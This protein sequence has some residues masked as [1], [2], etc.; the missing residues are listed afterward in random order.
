MG[1]LWS[2]TRICWPDIGLEKLSFGFEFTKPE[3]AKW[4]VCCTW[5]AYILPHFSCHSFWVTKPTV[6]CTLPPPPPPPLLTQF[7]ILHLPN[8]ANSP[9][10]SSS[11]WWPYPQQK[12]VFLIAHNYFFYISFCLFIN[13][14]QTYHPFSLILI[15]SCAVHSSSDLSFPWRLSVHLTSLV[16]SCDCRQEQTQR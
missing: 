7:D 10:Q 11:H 13:L 12:D 16:R 1:C 3:V 9:P 6:C 8:A 2:A 5:L 4:R 14:H 15:P